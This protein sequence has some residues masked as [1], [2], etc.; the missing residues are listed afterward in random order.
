[1][2]QVETH[3]YEIKIL[4]VLKKYNIMNED[5][6][7]VLREYLNKYSDDTITLYFYRT[8]GSCREWKFVV[9]Y[10]GGYIKEGDWVDKSSHKNP[11][12]FKII[13]KDEFLQKYA[14][15]KLTAYIYVSPSCS[16]SGKFSFQVEFIITKK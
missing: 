15:K 13:D 12:K 9:T 3:E 16:S 6:P 8:W 7:K 11:Y 4:N 5:I 14:D 10:E 1:M 2:S